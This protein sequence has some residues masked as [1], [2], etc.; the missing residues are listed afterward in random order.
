MKDLNATELVEPGAYKM[1]LIAYI[2]DGKRGLAYAFTPD[3]LSDGVDV[4][5]GYTSWI[6]YAIDHP[7]AMPPEA[8]RKIPDHSYETAHHAP[9]RYS[10]P[11]RGEVLDAI[12]RLL[13]VP[14]RDK[15][16]DQEGTDQEGAWQ[17]TDNKKL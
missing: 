6:D 4:I 16:N 13:L 11:T 15:A 12:S 3:Q 17:N 8:R 7:E 1:Q 2:K 5:S 10:N 9:E 14:L